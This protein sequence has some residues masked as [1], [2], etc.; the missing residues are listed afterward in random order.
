MSSYYRSGTV[1]GILYTYC[2]WSLRQWVVASVSRWKI[3]AQVK[4][5]RASR[6]IRAKPGLEL[7]SVIPKSLPLFRG[8]PM[9][10]LDSGSSWRHFP[11]TG[12]CKEVSRSSWIFFF[13]SDL[14]YPD[15]YPSQSVGVGSP[16]LFFFILP[17]MRT[18][19]FCGVFFSWVLTW[20]NKNLLILCQSP[21]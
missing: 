16:V 10:S 14:C 4:V 5:H 7:W 15:K 2:I 19:V 18:F 11:Q 17:C 12:K 21:K 13:L 20:Q 3:D 6:V 8:P 1:L 9:L